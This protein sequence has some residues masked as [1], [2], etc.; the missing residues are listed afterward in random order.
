MKKVILLAVCVGITS[1]TS[2]AAPS[3]TVL[4][5]KEQSTKVYYQKVQLPDLISEESFEGKHFKIVK[6]KNTNAI[7]FNEEDEGLLLRAATVYYHLS[8]ARDFWVRHIQSEVAESLPR[9]TIRIEITNQFN[10]L[11]HFSH[12]NKTPQYNNALSVPAGQTPEWVPADRQSQ[13]GKEIWF[14]P[15]KKILTRDLGPMGP[16]PLTR[17][18]QALEDPLLNYTENQFERS[19]LEHLFYPA[20]ADRP[21]HQSVFRYAGTFAVMKIIIYGS[22]FADSL[23]VDKYFYLDTAMVPEV[24]Y[25]EYAHLVLSDYL[26]MSHSTP[27]NEGIADYFAA[28]Q[29]QTRKVYNKVPGYSNAAAKDVNSKTT[30]SHWLES[31]RN[32]SS[33]FTL[34]VLWDVR[35][36]LGPE[37]G[38][39]VVYTA[40][41]Y[42]TTSSSTISD[43]LLRAILKACDE[44]CSSPRRDKYRL[45]Q[46]FRRKGF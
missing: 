33:D 34:S 40:R 29:S 30:Y 46:T 37:Q 42:L 13:W 10:E 45:F 39:R 15:Q 20:Y 35:E 11:G 36:T 4:L 26:E 14:R 27:V 17:S 18:L 12:D 44:K 32:S 21:L 43:G 1:A 2:F 22:K 24:A 38:D 3:F 31:N 28:V 19:L 7:S 41:K 8:Q 6:G 9:I 5:R 23:F 16:N 25:H